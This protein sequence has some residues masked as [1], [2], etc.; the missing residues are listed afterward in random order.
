MTFA[1]FF[2]RTRDAVQNQ[3]VT[4]VAVHPFT[5]DRLLAEVAADEGE[6]LVCGQV[7]PEGIAGLIHGIPVQLDP[8]V[9]RDSFRL[10]Y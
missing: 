9:S 7:V 1:E 3:P 2:S 10:D 4:G 8:A 5:W 6:P